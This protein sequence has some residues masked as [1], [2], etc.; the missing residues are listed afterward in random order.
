VFEVVLADG[1]VEDI[2]S[3]DVAPDSFWRPVMLE[4]L[5]RASAA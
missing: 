4:T 3:P 5:E 2:D 1:C